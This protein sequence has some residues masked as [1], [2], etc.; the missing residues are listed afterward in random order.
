MTARVLYE[1][2][3]VFFFSFL[4][5]IACREADSQHFTTSVSGEDDPDK[6][7]DHASA[8]AEID[9]LLNDAGRL[10]KEAVGIS[11]APSFFP[12]EIRQGA[13]YPTIQC[14]P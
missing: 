6:N 9:N 14:P 8:F 2:V 3:L 13:T 4:A 12:A 7:T 11:T 10:L 1:S 5:I